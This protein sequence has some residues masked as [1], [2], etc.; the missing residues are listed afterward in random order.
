MPD[1]LPPWMRGFLLVAGVYNLAWGI[2][3]FN[4][5]DAYYSWLLEI[6]NQAKW[7]VTYQGAGVIIFGLIYLLACLYPVRFWYLI[8]LG[9]FSKL[10]GAVGVYFFI[11]DKSITNHFI[12]HLLVNDFLWVVPLA[13]ITFR[14]FKLHNIYNYEKAA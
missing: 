2:F 13:V 6:N 14:A 5:Q 4:F 10:F 9:L 1:K 3:I 7:L 11:L 12:F 8:L